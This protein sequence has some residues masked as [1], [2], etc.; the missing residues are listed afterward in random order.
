MDND[1]YWP[2]ASLFFMGLSGC[3]WKIPVPVI[4][5]KKTI[6]WR[7]TII[8]SLLLF[9]V[10]FF[11]FGSWTLMGVFMAILISSISYFGLFFF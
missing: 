11:D 5:P 9:A 6:F 4:G 1:L 10:L 2:F 8:C 3:W 7:N